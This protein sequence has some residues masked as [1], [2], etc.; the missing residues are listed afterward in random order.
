[1][2]GWNYREKSLDL[3]SSLVV[4]ARSVSSKLN[5]DQMRNFNSLVKVLNLRYQSVERSEMYRAQL[6]NITKKECEPL[7]ERA[8]SIKKLIKMAYPSANKNLLYFLDFDHFVDAFP[9]PETRL[10]LREYRVRDIGEAEI[11]NRKG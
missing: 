8:Q 7:S 1:M 9:Y 10:R 11:R 4:N 6:K 5:E 2:Q 3:A